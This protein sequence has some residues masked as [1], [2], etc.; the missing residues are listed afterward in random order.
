[1]LHKLWNTKMIFISVQESHIEKQLNWQNLKRTNKPLIKW[2][3]MLIKQQCMM[4]RYCF[5]LDCIKPLL[6]PC[7][8][9]YINSDFPQQTHSLHQQSYTALMLKASSAKYNNIQKHMQPLQPFTQSWDAAHSIFLSFNT[10]N[11]LYN[12]FRIYWTFSN[13]A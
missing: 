9:K 3:F 4:G 7:M 5:E 8:H 11:T 2:S 1:M 13:S 10:L 6:K 12:Y